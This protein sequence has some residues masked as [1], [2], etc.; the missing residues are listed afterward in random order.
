[1]HPVEDPVEQ[2]HQSDTLNVGVPS[3]YLLHY[4]TYVALH[5]VDYLWVVLDVSI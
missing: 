2:S 3:P 5:D 4:G 1:M